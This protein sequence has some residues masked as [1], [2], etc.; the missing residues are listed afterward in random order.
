MLFPEQIYLNYDGTGD[1]TEVKYNSM[2]VIKFPVRSGHRYAV[3]ANGSK[4]TA[5][6]FY[7]DTTG[8]ATVTSPSGTD[9]IVLLDKGY[10]PGTVH[11]L[12]GD[13]N[14]DGSIDIS[15]ITAL[16]NYI[17]GN[18]PPVF[19]E[20]AADVNGDGDI[21]ISDITLLVNYILSGN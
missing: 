13:V 2:S 15:D 11:F 16:A 17:L 6:G 21:N 1:W 4:M 9:N 19:I 10:L 5:T 3:N 12:L 8:D 14:D 20:Q 7:F 18:I